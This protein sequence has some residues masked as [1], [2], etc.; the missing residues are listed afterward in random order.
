MIETYDVKNTHFGCG[1]C[2]YGFN[3][4][5]GYESRTY[6]TNLGSYTWVR[7]I[8]D[9]KELC[10]RVGCLSL[11]YS[12]ASMRCKLHSARVDSPSMPSYRDYRVCVKKERAHTKTNPPARCTKSST[13]GVD[14]N[15]DPGRLIAELNT[16]YIFDFLDNTLEEDPQYR[17]EVFEVMAFDFLDNT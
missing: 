3:F 15:L 13:C 1:P 7:D 10:E 8:R 9:C 11:I 2:P 6:E 5:K 16:A 4:K 12:P 17:P 14:S